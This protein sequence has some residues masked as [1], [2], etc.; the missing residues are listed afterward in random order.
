MSTADFNEKLRAH[1]A[2][3]AAVPGALSVARVLIANFDKADAAEPMSFGI[4]AATLR[5]LLA[6][7]DR[8]QAQVAQL[9]KDMREE[10]REFQRE[11]RDIAAEARRDERESGRGDY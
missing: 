2:H 11:A 8:L 9:Q 1:R 7:V 5:T 3:M 4:E 6:E 10:Q